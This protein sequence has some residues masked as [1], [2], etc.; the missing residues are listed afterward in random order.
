MAFVPA[1]DTVLARFNFSGAGVPMSINLHFRSIVSPITISM[2]QSLG[3]DL[4][5]WWNT[6]LGQVMSDFLTLDN[7]T[8][9]DQTV[10]NSIQHVEVVGTTGALVGSTLPT[11]VAFV[12]KSNT[13]FIGR[14]FRGRSYIP[15]L[16]ESDVTA[17]LMA[18]ITA[19]AIV[20]SFQDLLNPAVI[21]GFDPVVVS[22]FSNNVQRVNAVVTP[23][24]SYSYT[25]LTVD[26]RRK[27][28]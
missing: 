27:R 9:T 26:T 6:S 3:A 18:Q 12:I 20:A 22:K 17:N 21:A 14:S 7:I 8:I 13:N 4:A 11:N 28:L 25:D 5:T 16:R 19:D 10:P 15:L 24:V 2:L 23:I 1:L